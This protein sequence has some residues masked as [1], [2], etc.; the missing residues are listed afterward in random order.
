MANDDLQLPGDYGL[1]ATS[2]MYVGGIKI[3]D[4]IAA[5]A[6]RASGSPQV[7]N[8]HRFWSSTAHPLNYKFTEGIVVNLA[9]AKRI[10]YISLD[11]PS[12]PHHFYFYWWDSKAKTWKE[13]KGP[14]TGSIRVYIDGATPAVVGTAAAYQ[15][16]QHPSHYGAGHWLH[17]DIDVEPVTTTKLRF[18]GNRNFGSRKGGP[19]TPTGKPANYSLGVRNLDFGWRVRT[20]KDVPRTPRDPDVLTQNQSFTQTLD[21]M[22]SPVELSV[23][24]NRAADLLRGSQWQSEPMPVPYAVVNFYVDA[25]DTA[26]EPQVIDRFNITPLKSGANLNL[27]Y[28]DQVPDSDFGASDSPIVFPML[29]PAGAIDPAVQASGILFPNQVGYLDIANQAVQW[30]PNKPF[31]IALEFQPQWASTDTTPHIVLDAGD[32]QLSWNGG[33]FQVIYDEGALYQQPFEFSPNTRMHA[34]VSYDGQRLTFYM[35]ETGAAVNVTTAIQG[36]TSSVIRLGAEAGDSTAPVIFTGDYRLN[37]ML[38]K[39]EP[40]VFQ[41]VDGGGLAVP[42]SAQRFIDDPATYLDKPEYQDDD[43]GSTDNAVLRFLPSFVSGTSASSA[44]PYGFVGGPGTIF[45]DVVWTPVLRDYKLRAGMLQFQPTRARFFKFEFTNLT[46]EPYQTYMPLTRQV[47]TYSQ[48]AV[49]SVSAPQKTTQV[50]QSATSTGLTANADAT[51]DTVRYADTP[52]V[53][54]PSDADVLPTEALTARDVGVQAQL[55]RQGGLY[56]FDAWQPG[57]AAPRYTATS[58]H[59]YEEVEVGHAKRVAYFVGLSKL[60]MYRVDYTADDD[61]EQYIDLFDDTANIDPAYLTEKIVIGTTNFVTNPSFENG[62]TGQA[63]YTNGTATSGAIATVADG[64][65]GPN[66]LAV[67]ADALGSTTTDRIG[68]QATFADPDFTASVAYSVYAKQVTGNATLRLNVEY[69]DSLSGFISSDS[70]TFVP[71]PEYERCT[72]LLLPPNGTHSAKVYWWLE[73]GD[74]AVEYRFDGYQV[75]DLRITDYCD[76]D[77]DGCAWTGTPNASTSTRQDVNI[78]PWGWNGDWLVTGSDVSTSFTTMS[79]RFSSKR[80]VRGVQFATQ[81]SSAVQLVPDPDFA[82]DDL[83]VTWTSVGDVLSMEQSDDI[84]ATLGTAVKISRSSSRNTWGELRAA[85]PTWGDILTSPDHPS[86]AFL[87]GDKTD[88][89]FGGIALRNAVQVSESGRVWAAARVYADHALVAPLTLQILS[90]KGDVLAQ[91]DQVVQAGKVVE[92]SVGYTIGEGPVSTQTWANV[93]QLDPS[94]SAPTYGDLQDFTWGDLTDVEVSQLRD[95]RVRVIQAS[96]GEDTWYV[97]SLAL[98]DDAIL[99]E[100]SND[101]GATWWPALGVRN[102]PNGVL[103]FPNSLTPAPTD[104]TGLRWR[105][106]GYRPGLHVSALDIRPWYAE[107]VF[108]IPR[109]EPGVSGGPNIQPTDHYPPIEDDAYFKQW[110]DPIPQDWYF[111]YR[112]LLLLNRETVP[113]APIIKADTFA[114]PLSLLVSIEH[115]VP[116]PEWLDLYAETYPDR[117]GVPNA[118][119]QGTYVDDYDPADSY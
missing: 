111:T 116:P 115:I 17:Y 32:L 84:S 20:K 100:F 63:L 86:Y 101:D 24:E 93:M 78:R 19:K 88:V 113:V 65:F 76:G 91:K 107:T 36:L 108:G 95:L 109:R 80:R 21:I 83:T 67:T 39:Q 75:E 5:Q 55:D 41:S 44:N 104:P 54:N 34:F 99:W 71:G 13:F 47:K 103:I 28:S 3:E 23:R 25:R 33:V 72:A 68:W 112:Q 15:A 38:I 18:Q 29:R 35:P 49:Q 70:A 14:S 48:A 102:D 64:M 110:S 8:D 58:Q 43:D 73:A 94:P 118:D 53:S 57:T 10:N 105:V 114:N 52:A 77:Q 51:L 2:Q 50:Q 69:Y 31:W 11:L 98:F 96:A 85:Y 92:W 22:G 46:P 12:F 79:K 45:E 106:T 4:A 60:E 56:R 9:K 119:P 66:A 27:Y 87:E 62:T 89:G 6:V 81:Q 59:Y 74:G 7:A 82:S 40:L 61:T 97:D 37:A 117:Y 1:P 26:G 90:A 16:K 30:D 42:D